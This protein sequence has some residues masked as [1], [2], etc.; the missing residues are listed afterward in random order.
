MRLG[1]SAW[2]TVSTVATAVGACAIGATAM[3]P[4]A[5]GTAGDWMVAGGGVIALLGGLAYLAVWFGRR[6]KHL[7]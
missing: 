7:R 3:S 2:L 4:V 5:F 1:D 6:D